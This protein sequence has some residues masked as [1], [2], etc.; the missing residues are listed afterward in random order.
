M[1]S[2]EIA[3]WSVSLILAI[4]GIAFGIVASINSSRANKKVQALVSESWIADETNKLFF[5]NMKIVVA[6]N[7]YA[8]KALKKQITYFEYSSISSQTRWAPIGDKVQESLKKTEYN[9][10]AEHFMEMKNK[11]DDEF[12]EIITDF[13]ILAEDKKIDETTAKKLIK[14]HQNTMVLAKNIM[15]EYISLNVTK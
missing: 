4:T 14:H 1:P 11:S 13:S 15:K 12:K 6:E 10:I 9:V 5:K 8:I 3:L 2:Y 7:G